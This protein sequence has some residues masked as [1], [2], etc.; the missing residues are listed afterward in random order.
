MTTPGV[1]WLDFWCAAPH[2]PDEDQSVKRRN[3]TT[4]CGLRQFK[5]CG[6]ACCARGHGGAPGFEMSKGE[7]ALWERK[8]DDGVFRE[9]FPEDVPVPAR[10]VAK[11]KRPPLF[12]AFVSKEDKPSVPKELPEFDADDLKMG[13][14]V[15]LKSGG[16]HMTVLIPP[17]ITDDTL[18]CLWFDAKGQ[19]NR[20]T[21]TISVLQRPKNQP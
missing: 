16:P 5:A 17:T 6:D 1:E 21:L 18:E 4:I 8:V 15:Q 9:H 3:N 19:I 14:V 13:T 11:T 12:P 7:L 2:V 10:Q 20:T